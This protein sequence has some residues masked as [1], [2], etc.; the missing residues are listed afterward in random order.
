M[1]CFLFFPKRFLSWGFKTLFASACSCQCS[2]LHFSRRLGCSRPGPDRPGS[3]GERPGRPSFFPA[4]PHPIFLIPT[5]SG[6]GFLAVNQCKALILL[7]EAAWLKGQKCGRVRE[8]RDFLG[9][10]RR[11][12]NF[13]I[14]VGG[15]PT[16]NDN[17]T[18]R[19]L[20][21]LWSKNFL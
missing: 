10:R 5:T 18:V 14:H 4:S 16:K 12:R 2:P 3:S 17:F 1:F 19:K 8:F 7:R 20:A 11:I 21:L 9:W 13:S 15:D 6:R